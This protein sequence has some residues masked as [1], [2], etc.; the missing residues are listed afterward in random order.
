[1]VYRGFE[2]TCSIGRPGREDELWIRIISASF[3]LE[4]SKSNGRSAT[5]RMK[6]EPLMVEPKQCPHPVG[7][8]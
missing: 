8:A 3:T 5:L 1:M 2:S 4:K 7:A 6:D